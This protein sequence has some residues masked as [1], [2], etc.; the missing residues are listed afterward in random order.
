M[1]SILRYRQLVYKSILVLTPLIFLFF[2]CF[3]VNAQSPEITIHQG[4]I[5]E[6]QV[7][8]SNFV[9]GNGIYLT[10]TFSPA[11]FFTSADG[12]NWDR[13]PGPDVG[14]AGSEAWQR[15]HFAFG[16]GRW[17]VAAD[18]GQIFSSPDLVSWT[19]CV[20]NTKAKFNDV[21]YLDSTFMP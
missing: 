5:N 19:R 17:V 4:L 2:T 7:N 10:C 16:E 14:S 13:I 1:I 20:T 21:E 6:N 18:S 3:K 12:E 15:P 11:D 8:V 9:Y